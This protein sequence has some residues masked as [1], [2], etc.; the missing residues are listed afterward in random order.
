V[1][2]FQES[3]GSGTIRERNESTV[4]GKGLAVGGSVRSS[5]GAVDGDNVTMFDRNNILALRRPVQV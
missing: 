1:A 3:L 5:T 2:K 4:G